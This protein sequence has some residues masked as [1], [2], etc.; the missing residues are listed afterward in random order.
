M[1]FWC[2]ICFERSD[3]MYTLFIDT[4]SSNIVL[5]LYKDNQIVKKI[6]QESSMSH[7]VYVL[8]LIKELLE[9]N[10]I[11][12]KDLGLLLVVNGPGSFTG[13]RIGM[14]IA[15][16]IA[17]SLNIPIKLIDSLLIKALNIETSTKY[18]S[19]EDKHG[20]F[21]GVFNKDNEV[22][23]PYRYVKLS[24]YQ[25]LS[26]ENKYF[27]EVEINYEKIIMYATNI[28]TINPHS[29]NPLYIKDVEVNK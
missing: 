26:K 11:E 3:Y 2:I 29:A 23:E 14:T 12:L 17:Y 20:A 8:P 21:V 10:N 13:I 24:E 28:E 18:I 25:K 7:S 19:L 9:E 5:V 1:A 27:N 6:T 15:K 22:I 4:H 16:T